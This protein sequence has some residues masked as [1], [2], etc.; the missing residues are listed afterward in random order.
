MGSL[1]V[2][3]SYPTE[4]GEVV[5]L[6]SRWGLPLPSR[7]SSHSSEWYNVLRALP[8]EEMGMSTNLSPDNVPDPGGQTMYRLDL[9]EFLVEHP[10]GEDEP[11]VA[12][13]DYAP[14]ELATKCKDMGGIAAQVCAKY[15]GP[16]ARDAYHVDF[17]LNPLW[18]LKHKAWPPMGSPDGNWYKDTLDQKLKEISGLWKTLN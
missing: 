5:K 3:K 11:L 1:G 12:D 16:P 17:K 10:F 9:K 7:M 2:R 6:L 4:E 18:I 13:W 14:E 8:L 15:G